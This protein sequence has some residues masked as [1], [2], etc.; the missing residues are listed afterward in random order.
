MTTLRREIRKLSFEI[1][2]H[3]YEVPPVDHERGKQLAEL[4]TTA[5]DKLAK[6]KLTQVD[7]FQLAMTSD[8]WDQMRSDGVPFVDMWTA[9][10]ACL[11]HFQTLLAAR[12]PAEAL[13]QAE[14]AARAIW[15]SGVD[16]EA[17]AAWMAAQQQGSTTPPSTQ[18]AAATTTPRPASGTGTRKTPARKT[19]AGSR[20]RG[21]SSSRTGTR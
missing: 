12:N 6:S 11:A 20:S 5:P 3:T 15:E 10:M 16:P 21:R 19:T 4:F 7:M 1:G 9:G 13:D 17:V 2:D 18:P 8:L 14:Q